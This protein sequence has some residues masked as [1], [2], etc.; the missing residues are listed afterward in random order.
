MPQP[1]H[2]SSPKSSQITI[3]LPYPN[4]LLPIPIPKPITLIL[5]PPYHPNSTLLQPL[6]PR[7]YHHINPHPPH[8]LI[9]NN[10]PIKI[11]PQDRT[12]LQKL[13]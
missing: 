1:I 10:T 9:T 11:P 2:F 3:Q 6:E 4:P 13:N 7:L 8:Y 12:T 5:P